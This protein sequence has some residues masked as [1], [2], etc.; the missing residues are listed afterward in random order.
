MATLHN[1]YLEKKCI[2]LFPHKYQQIK[3]N[4][5]LSLTVTK[6]KTRQDFRDDVDGYWDYSDYVR[7]TVRVGQTVTC[8]E[9]AWGVTVG[10]TGVVR[11]VNHHM[12]TVDWKTA[13]RRP[14]YIDC[15]Y[16]QLM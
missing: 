15:Y 4:C 6:Y 9:S 14:K 12:L 11:Q 13:G 3:Q 5:Q 2:K 10:D 7:L 8:R 16:T 1:L